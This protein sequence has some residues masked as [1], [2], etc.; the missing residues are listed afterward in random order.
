MKG[1]DENDKV[2]RIV[3]SKGTFC[4]VF[5]KEN[6]SELESMLVVENEGKCIQY[7]FDEDIPKDCRRIC[8]RFEKS[9]VSQMA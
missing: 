6:G 5:C 2:C 3:C 4:S 8:L 9:F 7:C 1:H